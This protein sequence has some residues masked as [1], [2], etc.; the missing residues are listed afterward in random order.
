MGRTPGP[1]FFWSRR[2]SGAKL[3]CIAFGG[4]GGKEDLAVFPTR[5]DQR[6]EQ[7][8]C[9][10]SFYF[11]IVTAA[12]ESF[13]RTRNGMKKKGRSPRGFSQPP[14]LRPRSLNGDP[15]GFRPLGTPGARVHS[16]RE[17][18]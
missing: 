17:N 15:S 13:P 16:A 1:V 9:H 6:K 2:W 4:P 11:L 5:T 10:I 18:L 14:G 3:H 12:M 7:A 8:R